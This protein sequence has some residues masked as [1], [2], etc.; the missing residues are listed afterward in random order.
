[1]KRILL[2]LMA[3]AVA[4]F[5]GW[6]Y[7]QFSQ[8]LSSAPVAALL[9]RD[10]IFLAQIPDFNRARDEWQHCDIYQL[11]REPAVQDFLSKPLGKAP[12]TDAV[13]QTLSEI[14][15]LAP[16]NSFFAL[17]S[18]DNNNPKFVGGFRFGGSQEEAE[19]I[20]GKWRSVLMGQN[21]SLK[22]E[23]V[24]HQGHEIDV[25]KTNSFSVATAYD[26]PWFFAA[27]D[28]PELQEVLDRSDRRASSPDNRLDKDDTY[29]AASS[30]RPSNYV[31]FFYLQPKTFSQRLAALRAAVGSTP[32]PGEGTMLEKMR[33]VTGS[34]RFE[35]GKI[36]DVFFMGMPKLEQNT[37]LARSSLSLGTKE[38]FFYLAMLVNLG[39]RMDTLNQAA[40]FAGTKIFQALSDSGITAADWKAA[41]GIELGSLADW[42]SNAHWP[43]LLVTVPVTDATKAGKIVEALLRAE[44]NGSWTTTEKDGVRYFSKQSAASFV[45]ITPT[46]A[47]SDRILI[48]GLDPTSVEQAINRGRN[49]SS[50]FAD[51]QTFKGAARLLP[52]PTNFFAYI[53]TAQLYSRLD[54]SLRP[55]LLMA[56]AFVPAVAGSIDPAKLPAPEVITKHLSPIVSSQRYD[57]DGYMAESIGPITLDQLGIGVAIFS[58]FGAAAARQTGLGA[59]ATTPPLTRS[60]SP[61]P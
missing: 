57:V 8:Q 22:R 4:A 25:T 11:Y 19:R 61:T 39:E 43:S 12:K 40:A 35:N 9:P 1:M 55:M 10:T 6:Y 27:T 51:S 20:I 15:Q 21:S 16:K 30:R 46:M 52:A 60:P 44:E 18:I 42:P 38:T 54:A 49:G 14:E 7:W 45:A 50:E 31:A 32:S 2:L 53:D 28:V 17:T 13:S 24:Q 29:R 47:L 33:C 41:F 3:L 5:A 58:S 56:A 23:K 48:F 37:T 59:P 26:P 36:H 34:M